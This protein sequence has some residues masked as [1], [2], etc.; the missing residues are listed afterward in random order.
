MRMKKLFV[1][2]LMIIPSLA[3]GQVLGN[4]QSSGQ[5]PDSINTAKT[6][7]GPKNMEDEVVDASSLEINSIHLGDPVNSSNKN[8]R[9]KNDNTHIDYYRNFNYASQI[10]STKARMQ[11]LIQK[12]GSMGAPV[13]MDNSMMSEINTSVD[14]LL[15]SAV[16]DSIRT[17]LIREANRLDSLQKL[18]EARLALIRQEIEEEERWNDQTV[19]SALFAEYY[20][21][22]NPADLGIHD[23]RRLKKIKKE[24]QFNHWEIRFDG[25]I[26]HSSNPPDW[27]G[28]IHASVLYH[29]NEH[30]AFGVGTG[31]YHALGRYHAKATPLIGLFDVSTSEK[32][33]FIGFAELY[34][35]VLL[36]KSHSNP[37]K[38][39]KDD[40]PVC[41]LFGLKFGV[42]YNV[43]PN[44]Q[45]RVG[46]NVFHIDGGNDTF[47][48]KETCVGP[49]GSLCFLF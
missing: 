16:E 32:M 33:G 10:D 15:Q 25:G 8:K 49:T 6:Y 27:N 13:I 48:T 35:G 29:S 30:I 17:S 47:D 14:S 43:V 40:Y 2:L 37:V 31:Y 34:G 46:M 39:P 38:D 4:P 7:G 41:P 1:P 28:N 26:S 5:E 22:I 36:D 20:P 44:V 3:I 23:E 9:L 24:K 45:F 42:G 11:R 18:E 12:R 19:D 21:G